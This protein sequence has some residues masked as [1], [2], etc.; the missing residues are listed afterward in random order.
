MRAFRAGFS[1]SVGRLTVKDQRPAGEVG[2]VI[3]GKKGSQASGI[4]LRI[5]EV[6]RRKPPEEDF[7]LVVGS[8]VGF[9]GQGSGRTEV[10]D[11]APC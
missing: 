3:A 6:A 1:L 2:G 11:P 4:M 8:H 7:Q 10:A 9:T 5:T